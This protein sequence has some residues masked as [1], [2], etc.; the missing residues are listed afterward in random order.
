MPANGRL[1]PSALRAILKRLLAG[2]D[3]LIITAFELP[4]R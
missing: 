4:A 1:Q 2:R 3:F